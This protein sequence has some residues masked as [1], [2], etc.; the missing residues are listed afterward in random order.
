[1]GGQNRLASF[2]TSRRKSHKKRYFKADYCLIHWLINRLIDV[3]PFA[4]TWVG[5]TV[6]IEL[7]ANFISARMSE[8]HRK[9]TQVQISNGQ[10]ESQVDPGFQLASICDSV[11]PGL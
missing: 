9:S 2:L 5:E 4:L 3:T 10:M 8:S 6:Q 11:W 7:R 1:M